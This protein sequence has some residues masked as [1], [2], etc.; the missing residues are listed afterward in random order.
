VDAA[1]VALVSVKEAWA[2]SSGPIRELLV[3]VMSWVAQQERRRLVERTKAGLARARANGKKIGRPRLNPAARD[4]ALK[5]VAAGQANRRRRAHRRPRGFH[6]QA[7]TARTRRWAMTEDELKVRGFQGGAA[8]LLS[9]FRRLKGRDPAYIVSEA[10]WVCEL[11]FGDVMDELK[12]EAAG[13]TSMV[14]DV[15][16]LGIW[17]D[18][19][20]EE[21]ALPPRVPRRGSWQRSASRRSRARRSCFRT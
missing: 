19:N 4:R 20:D 3:A 6:H 1:H 8:E 17:L 7:R 2:D 9:T 15:P 16:W 5:L 21:D 12:E 18:P 13:K 10:G 14:L 11:V